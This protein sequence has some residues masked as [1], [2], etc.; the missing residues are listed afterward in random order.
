MSAL[1][2]EEQ[3]VLQQTIAQVQALQAQIQQ[4]GQHPQAVRMPRVDGPSTYDGRSGAKIDQ[5]KRELEMQFTWHRQDTDEQKVRYATMFLRGAALDWWQSLTT[6]PLT[7][8]D[9]INALTERFQPITTA[10]TARTKLDALVQGPKQPIHNYIMEFRAL[11][12]HVPSMDEGDKLHRFMNGLKKD[13][14]TQLRIQG[15]TSL[16]NAIAMAARVGQLGEFGAA[17]AVSSQRTSNGSAPMELDSILA[18][19]GGDDDDAGDDEPVT[20]TRGEL[21]L[22]LAAIR[23]HRGDAS[24]FQDRF[25]Q[26]SERPLPKIPHLSEAQVKARMENGECFGCASKEHRSRNCPKR[27]VDAAGKVSWPQAN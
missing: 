10:Q 5:W 12:V 2:P 4:M 23:V 26:R 16:D 9:M 22:A 20:M 11:L 24:K 7:W 1:S 6:K 14:Q 15:V 17:A 25:R 19:I 8:L 3:H 18:A 27:R 21:K 13:I